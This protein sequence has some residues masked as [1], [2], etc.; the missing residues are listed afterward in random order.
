MELTYT[1]PPQS[2]A[3]T[4]WTVGTGSA[5]N[6]SQNGSTD[7][8][9]REYG[10]DPWDRRAVLWKCTPNGLSYGGDGGWNS[11][12]FSIDSTALYRFSCWFR[13]TVLGPGGYAYLG[14]HGYGTT[15][16]VYTYGGVLDTNP[17]HW[18]AINNINYFGG[19][20]DEWVLAVGHIFPHDTTLNA[21]KN[22]SDTGLWRADGTY[23]TS[24]YSAYPRDF[25][26]HSSS[27]SANHRAYLFYSDTSTEPVQHMVYPR[28]D[29]IDGNHP[30]LKDLLRDG[31]S[32]LLANLLLN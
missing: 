15:N 4:Y 9:T 6:F 12:T 20:E 25:K 14:S 24:Y 10:I 2:W 26:W 8:N 18:I 23:V 13:R 19:S 7:E 17:Y 16:G 5:T 22:H 1:D 29:K 21:E 3:Q 11:G 27:T 28:V 32:Y 31:R 30:T